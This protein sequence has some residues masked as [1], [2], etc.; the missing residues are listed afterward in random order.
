MFSA[1]AAHDAVPDG[2]HKR[3]LFS[4]EEDYHEYIEFLK[5]KRRVHEDRSDDRRPSKRSRTREDNASECRSR[6][7][8]QSNKTR[9]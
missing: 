7:Q 1:D 3:V 8:T 2:S 4:D 5:M 9:N 6:R